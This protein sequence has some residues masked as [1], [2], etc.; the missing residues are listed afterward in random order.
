[1]PL[2]ILAMKIAAVANAG[3]S[4]QMTM[5]AI[6]RELQ[7]RGHEFI[8][9]GT[10]FQ[11]NQLKLRDV[12]FH[13]LRTDD[14]D[15]AERYVE[16]GRLQSE[17]PVSATTAFSATITYMKSMAAVLCEQAPRVLK[18]RRVD[19][20]LADQEEPAAATAAELA[21]LPYAS[22]CNS[23]PL[24]EDPEIPPD[25]MDWQYSTSMLARA[26]NRLGYSVRN[27][28]I[29]GVHRIVNSFRERA[30]LRPYRRPDDSFSGLAQITQLVKEFDFPRK[31]VR[32]PLHYVG[33]FQRQAL[34]LRCLFLLSDWMD[35]P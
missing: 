35:G 4:H 12:S 13:V 29:R 17:A 19:F 15:P 3:A 6:G 34:S 31:M 11:A 14:K 18:E 5:C 16:Q 23:L 20:V 10:R 9:L 8:L 25:F 27:L 33:P 21:G 2:A 22:I 24:N 1:M 30:G 26:R 32:A 28:F 7:K